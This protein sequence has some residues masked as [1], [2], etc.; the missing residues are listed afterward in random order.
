M[1]PQGRSGPPR[2]NLQRVEESIARGGSRAGEPLRAG[3]VP[4]LCGGEDYASAQERG[5]RGVS[6]EWE[7]AGRDLHG[8]NAA[9][10]GAGQ[11]LHVAHRPTKPGSD[12]TGIQCGELNHGCRHPCRPYH[13][14]IWPYN[15]RFYSPRRPSD[16]PQ[17]GLVVVRWGEGA[18]QSKAIAGLPLRAPSALNDFGGGAR[19]SF[20]STPVRRFP[21][22]LGGLG[23]T[24]W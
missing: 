21:R 7:G 2:R 16:R 24:P 23:V 20:R 11:A 3:G 8:G 13:Y 15:P 6:G 5:E 19:R 10:T 9:A 22:C 14:H 18:R 12:T 1:C 4:G 17:C